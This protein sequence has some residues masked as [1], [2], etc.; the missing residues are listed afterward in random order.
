MKPTTTPQQHGYTL[1]EMLVSAG[2]LAFGLVLL[3]S[4]FP[5]GGLARRIAADDTFAH[6]HARNVLATLEAIGKAEFDTLT[7]SDSV[8][9]SST[10]FLPLATEL[11]GHNPLSDNEN[12]TVYNLPYPA[13]PNDPYTYQ[14]TIKDRF[15]EN[16]NDIIAFYPHDDSYILTGNLSLSDDFDDRF[17]DALE[18]PQ[19]T[20]DH[21][22]LVRERA[23]A[24]ASVELAIYVFR[25]DDANG[26]SNAS[27]NPIS[28]DNIVINDL[29]GDFETDTNP[30]APVRY[31]DSAPYYEELNLDG[32]LANA[33]IGDLGNT[34][35]YDIQ[36]PTGGIRNHTILLQAGNL[37][38]NPAFVSQIA[39]SRD[40]DDDL[41]AL[42][43]SG[44]PP[45]RI[46][47]STAHN[48]TNTV[49]YVVYW[50]PARTATI[51]TG[52]L[53]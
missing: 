6:I 35:A 11:D 21:R 37:G 17:P 43:G 30:Y 24:E 3:A 5:A 47:T 42:L 23:N 22:I 13:P 39:G 28:P 53:P 2:I 20:Y 32:G 29:D 14:Q 27:G 31:E 36:L 26:I 48:M 9:G 41:I 44:R 25:R 18:A 16:E 34:S 12:E 15:N 8:T 38:G 40:E 7:N 45:A 50:L 4:L 52:K 51:V 19:H 46:E 49:W 10:L 1:I 33:T